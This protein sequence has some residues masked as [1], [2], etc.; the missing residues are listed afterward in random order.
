MQRFRAWERGRMPAR[1]F[2]PSA[3][4]DSDTAAPAFHP[5]GRGAR[6]RRPRCRRP[7][8]RSACRTSPPPWPGRPESP[9][10]AAARPSAACCR[11][12]RPRSEI[13]APARGGCG[14]RRTGRPLRGRFRH[15]GRLPENTSP[16]F[17]AESPLLGEK[18]LQQ[19]SRFLLQ[20]AADHD[21]LMIEAD[22]AGDL[23]QRVAAAGLRV[24]RAVKDRR[25]C[26]PAR[27]RRRTSGTAPA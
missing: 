16:S 14:G 6:N 26:G 3:D 9:T 12:K 13:D 17:L 8:R 18:F 19:R 10:K 20:N 21:G 22:V 23:K 4:R 5:F 15:R 25:E 2:L 7:P 1:E 27:S 24:G 11:A